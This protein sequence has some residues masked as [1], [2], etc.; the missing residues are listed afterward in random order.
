MRKLKSNKLKYFLYIITTKKN[1]LNQK[2]IIMCRLKK[3]SILLLYVTLKN[4]VS[5]NEN[6]IGEVCPRSLSGLA[7]YIIFLKVLKITIVP[8]VF[9]CALNS[10]EKWIILSRW[11]WILLVY[12]IL[13]CL[14]FG[15]FAS[16]WFQ[17]RCFGVRD[18]L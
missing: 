16:N 14:E 17:S 5:M 4:T 10:S 15:A 12:L 1:C 8:C 7:K 3:E 18:N 11:T 9:Y 2:N 6:W 13:L